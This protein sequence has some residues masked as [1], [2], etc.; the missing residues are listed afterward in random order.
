MRL[1]KVKFSMTRHICQHVYAPQL[2]SGQISHRPLRK[3]PIM[4]TAVELRV[5]NRAVAMVVREKILV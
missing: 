4:C 1:F 5:C 3:P 2:G